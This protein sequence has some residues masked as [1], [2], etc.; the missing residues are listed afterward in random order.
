MRRSPANLERTIS[1]PVVITLSLRIQAFF[2]HD[3]VTLYLTLNDL[4]ISAM[5]I[6]FSSSCFTTYTYGPCWPT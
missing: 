3:Q 5:S 1:C 2:D 6:F 4:T